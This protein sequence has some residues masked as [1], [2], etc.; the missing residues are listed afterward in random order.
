MVAIVTGVSGGSM[1]TAASASVEA[2]GKSSRSP[3]CNRPDCHRYVT[4]RMWA[5]P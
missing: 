2:P 4:S 1:P 5:L 3:W